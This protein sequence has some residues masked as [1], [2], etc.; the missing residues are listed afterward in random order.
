MASPA[1]LMSGIGKSF[2][3]VRVLDQV[4]FEVRQGEVHAL[5]GGNGAGKSTLMKILE[6]IYPL[7]E[8]SIEVEG[9][10]VHFR[11]SQDA[12]LAGIAMI[13]QEFSLVSTLSVAQNVFLTREA[14]GRLGFI[15]DREME[16]RTRLLFGSI[17]VDIDPRR[18]VDEL[19]TAERQLTEIAKALSQ[20]ARV[21]IM[22]EPT[23]SLG[24][25]E[26]V[27]L[28]GLMERLKAQGISIVYISHRMEEIF[29]VAD[30]VTVLRDGRNVWTEAIDQVTPKAVINSIVGRE[31][32]RGFTWR[33]REG[34]TGGE[35]LLEV[36]G[37]HSG[38]RLRGV[39][40]VLRRGEIVGLAGLMG[41]GRSELARAIFGI[42]RVESGEILLAG[43]PVKLGDPQDAI[44]SRI[45]L[46]PEDR[47]EQ[48]LVMDHSVR[49][50]A[51]LPLLARLSRLGIVNDARGDRVVDSYVDSLAIKTRGTG[52]P[53]R[54]LSGGNQQKVVIAKWLATEPAILIMDEPT[55]GVDIGTKYEIVEK[56]REFAAAGN[57][58][59]FISSELP[60]LLAVSDRVLVMRD[61]QVERAIPRAEIA[62]EGDLHHVVQGVQ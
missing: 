14:S 55:A 58:V 18:P 27:L 49:E 54:L 3:G 5:V 6:G 28:F 48:G 15:D 7:E 57:A 9:R 32:D 46:I 52:L 34:A 10:P 13:F 26:T 4:D 19:P 62:S 60:E 16:R 45:A 11:S 33:P 17:D 38:P 8:G 51:L 47:H 59:V 23:S 35:V 30:R 20:D 31:D 61:G 22:D 37:L 12:R 41:S 1:V 24:R 21:L 36:R 53:V 40:L 2:D 50:N 42:D 56:I 29:E 43:Q 39:D 25:S 44:D